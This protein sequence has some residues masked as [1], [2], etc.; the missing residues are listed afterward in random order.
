MR[1]LLF[2]LG[3]SAVFAAPVAADPAVTGAE[4]AMRQAPSATA[5]IV[6]RVPANA[7]IDLSQ[8]SGAWCYVSWRNRFGYLPVAAIARAPY[9]PGPAPNDGPHRL[10]VRGG[11]RSVLLW[12]W[13][14]SL[15]T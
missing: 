13:L 11:G 4:A 9:P 12:L 6:Q 15:V 10:M 8:C 2:A 5:R 14:V 3:S 1:A 7:E